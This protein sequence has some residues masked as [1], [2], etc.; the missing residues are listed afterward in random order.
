MIKSYTVAVREIDES[1]AAVGQAMEAVASLP[2]LKNTVGIITAH[3]ESVPSGVFRDVAR[4]LPFPSVGMTTIAHCAG[5]EADTYMLS[6][7][8]LTSDD[9]AFSCGASAPIPEK[10]GV[11]TAREAVRKCY[12]ELTGRLPSEPRLALLYS[13]FFLAP[14][15]YQFT[16][17]ISEIVPRL[18]VFGAVANDD[19]QNVRPQTNA[20]ILADG[21]LYDDRPAL[22]LVSGNVSPKFYIASVTED[23]II[24]PRV[25][26]IT[27]ADGIKL[28][29][30]NNINAPD[31]FKQIGFLCAESGGWRNGG[32]GLLSS[33]F[34]L[35]INDDCGGAADITRIPF[36]VDAEAV[37]CAGPLIEGA[38][39]SIAFNTQDGVVETA[40]RICEQVK[41]DNAGGTAIMYTCIGRRYGLL[42]EPMAELSAIIDRM[43][44]GFVYTAAYGSGEMCP[45]RITK[46][47]AFN[48]D[49]SQTIVAC[50]F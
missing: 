41:R 19:K 38:A 39:I 21:E 9:C 6:I 23:A 11:E 12:G 8:T 7:L 3:P 14:R 36:M 33:L 40:S 13:Q 10:C 44:D 46:D 42:G 47:K 43:G 32:E 17:A 16:G 48:Q 18:P 29:K 26:V 50:V 24:M 30:V 4:A 22:L 28:L 37:Y 49:H 27:E 45:T 25:G 35:H 15:Q 34:V 2:L 1:A 20:R 5:A 31:F